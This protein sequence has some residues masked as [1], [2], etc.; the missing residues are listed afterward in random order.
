MF[1]RTK[2]ED[3]KKCLEGTYNIKE[4]ELTVDIMDILNVLEPYE[5]IN[6]IIWDKEEEADYE[7]YIDD[8][9]EIGI[10]KGWIEEITAD[11]TYNWNAPLINHID[12]RTYYD[13]KEDE[14]I[15]TFRVHCGRG[16][17]RTGYSEW[18]Y[19]KFN[20]EEEFLEL[21]LECS[22]SVEVELNDEIYYVEVNA[23]SDEINLFK[24]ENYKDIC[25]DDKYD[26]LN[27]MEELDLI[28]Y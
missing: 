28:E 17:V 22:K 15:V 3:V 24:Y 4:N 25:G 16:D 5:V 20:Y 1:G 7:Y 12:F 8:Y 2:I 19:L 10:E 21:F 13:T 6:G 23:L 14:Y 26:L 18:M 9:L 11:N 27:E